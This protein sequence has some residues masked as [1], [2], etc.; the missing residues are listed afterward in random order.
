MVAGVRDGGSRTGARCVPA[1][2]RVCGDKVGMA[3]IATA[4]N[5]TVACFQTWKGRSATHARHVLDLR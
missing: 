3:E 1:N 2:E 4:T 5:G